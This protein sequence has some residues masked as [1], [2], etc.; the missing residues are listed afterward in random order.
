MFGSLWGDAPHIACLALPVVDERPTA[1]LNALQSEHG[2]PFS[3]IQ[4][5]GTRF[6]PFGSPF[7]PNVFG[8]AG[9]YRERCVESGVLPTLTGWRQLFDGLEDDTVRRGLDRHALA[10][11]IRAR[12]FYLN[13]TH[14]RRLVELVLNPTRFV[15]ADD[16]L[17]IDSDLGGV[18]EVIGDG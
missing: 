14:Q 7:Q 3:S 2:F 16:T 6:R 12:R 13:V 8:L 17:R 5:L 9:R 15:G 10:L 11:D 18:G 4:V 1:E